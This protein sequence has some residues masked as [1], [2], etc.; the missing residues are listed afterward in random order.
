MKTKIQNSIKEHN[1]CYED[2]SVLI[3]LSGGA[4]SVALLLM[5]K[6]LGYKVSACH[7]NHQL[8]GEESDR[9][10]NFCRE[11][12]KRLGVEL[13]VE[14]LDVKKFCEENKKGTEEG[15]R[16]L[17]YETFDKYCGEGQIATAHTLSDNIETF[18]INFTRG[19]ALTGLCAI[20]PKRGNIIRPL[21][22]CTREEIE[23]YLAEKGESFVTD[24][25][26]LTTDYTRNKIRHNVIPLLREINPSLEKSFSKSVSSLREDNRFLDSVSHSLLHDITKDV[27][28][29]DTELLKMTQKSIAFRIIAQILKHFDLECNREKIESIYDLIY[30]E[31]K[32]NISGDVYA[33]VK[34]GKLIIAYDEKTQKQLFEQELDFENALDFMGKMIST[35]KE[36]ISTISNIHRNF[37]KYTMDY[38]KIQ[39]KAFVRNRREGDRIK[40]SGRAYTTSIKK[41]FNKD[42]ELDKR[43]EIAFICDDSGVI[44]V[45][46]YGIAQRVVPDKNTKNIV[47]INIS[48]GNV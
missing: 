21:I 46:G 19:T 39:G 20:P 35:D 34:K 23:Q 8:R 47:I 43:D 28:K 48:E 10:E 36:E 18:L 4:D 33:I 14:K 42:I 15:A 17:R 1:M 5:M 22:N 12:C 26:N 6:E 44:F 40:F 3:G 7:I 30:K 24:S 13:F 32:Y 2:D 45:E 27:N 11:L 16:I 41:L 25:T 38:D 9:D 31:G 37:T 29:F